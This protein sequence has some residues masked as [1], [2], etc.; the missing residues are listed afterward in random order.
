MS[1]RRGKILRYCLLVSIHALEFHN[2]KWRGGWFLGLFLSLLKLELSSGRGYDSGT[3]IFRCYELPGQ[4]IGADFDL[5]LVGTLMDW[6]LID[7]LIH[8][9]SFL[10]RWA[11]G[12]LL[13]RVVLTAVVV[14]V[15]LT[16]GV[17]NLSVV[18]MT[19]F[20]RGPLVKCRL[21]LFGL[22]LC[23]YWTHRWSTG[24]ALPARSTAR[25][26]FP[27]PYRTKRKMFSQ[28]ALSKD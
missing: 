6:R 26:T 23:I 12:V 19:V 3:S 28:V 2:Q 18:A 21:F 22:G 17:T 9:V 16:R 10:C 27:S 8:S 20:R 24:G 1:S 25:T 15:R 5:V 14:W 11:F 13:P 4:L 7:S